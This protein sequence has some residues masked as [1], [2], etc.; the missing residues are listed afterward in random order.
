MNY[1]LDLLKYVIFGKCKLILLFTFITFQD[2]Y[3]VF[4]FFSN[5]N[6]GLEPKH[7]GRTLSEMHPYLQK[8]VSYIEK[9]FVQCF[10]VV[11]FFILHTSSC[12]S[13]LYTCAE[14]VKLS[15]IL[16]QV[17]FISVIPLLVLL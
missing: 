7:L 8:M 13:T 6:A 11:V 2:I 14:G 17:T 15:I 3:C 16:W 1:I 10:G 4:F 5:V 9:V 12:M